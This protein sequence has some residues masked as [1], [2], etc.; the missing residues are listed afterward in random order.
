MKF[1]LAFITLIASLLFP[2]IISAQTTTF[3]KLYGDLTN[4]LAGYSLISIDSDIYY[5]G[6]CY[7]AN[8]DAFLMKLNLNGDTLWTKFFDGGAN[9]LF[10]VM[11]KLQS[12]DLMMGGYINNIPLLAC[13][14][15]SGNI[16]WS[17]IISG[18][19]LSTIRKIL[20]LS[21]NSVLCLADKY[22]VS[23]I[24]KMSASGHLQWIKFYSDINYSNLLLLAD[25]AV[26]AVGARTLAASI[27]GDA[28]LSILKIDTA[29]TLLWQKVMG[30]TS[31]Q[32]AVSAVQLSDGM[33]Y[34]T[35]QQNDPAFNTDILLA[36]L[37]TDG[38]LLW[39]KSF[40]GLSQDVALSIHRI[41]DDNLLI[42]GNSFNASQPISYEFMFNCDKNGNENWFKIYGDTVTSSSWDFISIDSS[43]FI[44][45]LTTVYDTGT[46]Q[47]RATLIRTDTTGY[48]G[49]Y[50]YSGIINSNTFT[51]DTVSVNT[52]FN[53]TVT[54]SDTLLTIHNGTAIRTL[55]PIT[56]IDE[57]ESFSSLLFYPNPS[58]SIFTL[59][60]GNGSH[61]REITIFNL[62][63]VIVTRLITVDDIKL[64]VIPGIYFY[65]IADGD[66][67]YSGKFVKL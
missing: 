49:C 64:D 53:N 37:N 9:E 59:K 12:G 58:T 11:A 27:F 22:A 61:T 40:S 19:G 8:T 30:N 31:F 35:G 6:I 42:N 50:Q 63:G 4:N 24:F 39:S 46:P 7:N 21:D 13:T 15:T 25:G 52:E 36:K 60:N 66:H 67:I 51:F 54:F 2:V 44:S 55:C 20:P 33:V 62:Q 18:S 17:K 41:H 34:V 38:H 16:L 3:Q 5:S 48:T 28:D 65:R 43:Y 45:G 10:S 57:N 14:D 29:G 32:N 1:A 47:Y 56:S 23:C 26:M